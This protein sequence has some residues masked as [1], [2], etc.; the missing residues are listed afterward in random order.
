M[1][2]E[3]QSVNWTWPLLSAGSFATAWTV[4][5]RSRLDAVLLASVGVFALVQWLGFILRWPAFFGPALLVGGPLQYV[6]AAGLFVRFFLTPLR[7]WPRAMLM[8][9]AVVPLLQIISILL[10]FAVFYFFS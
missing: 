3:R 1:G 6:F 7:G 5:D 9:A 4:R 2:M 10:V 8:I